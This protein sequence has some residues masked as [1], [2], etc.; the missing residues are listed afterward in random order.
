MFNRNLNYS[1]CDE[2]NSFHVFLSQEKKNIYF[3]L[4]EFMFDPGEYRGFSW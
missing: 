3:I 4:F 2:E 1:E